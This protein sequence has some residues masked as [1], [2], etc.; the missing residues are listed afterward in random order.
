ME[1][2]NR[3]GS[4]TGDPEQLDQTPVE[5]PLG[6]IRPTPLTDLIAS[7]VHHAVQTEQKETFET[8]EESDD[9]TEENEELLDMSAYTLTNLQ[10]QEPIQSIQPEPPELAPEPQ[11]NPTGDPPNPNVVEPEKP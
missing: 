11:P 5:M 9:F 10:E 7:M 8:E 3:W 2:P 6:Y 1:R 4:V